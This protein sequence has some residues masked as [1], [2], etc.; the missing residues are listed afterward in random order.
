MT[1]AIIIIGPQKEGVKYNGY[2]AYQRVSGNGFRVYFLFP[3]KWSHSPASISQ[4]EVDLNSL[5]FFLQSSSFS[6]QVEESR[7]R[8]V[9]YHGPRT[10]DIIRLPP[11]L[12]PAQLIN[13]V[14]VCTFLIKVSFFEVQ[15][16][17]LPSSF[18]SKKTVTFTCLLFS[19]WSWCK[20]SFLFLQSSS[21]SS[22]VEKSRIRVVDY[23]GP[24][25][26]DIRLPPG[27]RPAQLINKVQVY[28]FQIK[29]SFEVQVYLPSSF[30]SK[31]LTTFTCPSSK[32]VP[33]LMKLV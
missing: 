26:M 27:L 6:S 8:V 12:R 4:V 18:S 23:H 30:S 29:F 25:T 20:F 13:K 32:V 17:L 19:S 2:E 28:T 15:V 14:Q 21:F 16:Y 11:G 3:P 22:Q 7:I 9:D 1:T 33:K 10:M 24:R 31:T 5:F